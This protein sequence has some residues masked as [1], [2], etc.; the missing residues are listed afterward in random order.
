MHVGITSHHSAVQKKAPMSNSGTWTSC[1]AD[2][3]RLPRPALRARK[4]P[5][6]FIGI[7]SSGIVGSIEGARRLGDAD[8]VGGSEGMSMSM[9][10]EDLLRIAGSRANME[11][12]DA[13]SSSRIEDIGVSRMIVDGLSNDQERTRSSPRTWHPK[14]AVSTNKRCIST[15]LTHSTEYTS[16]LQDEVE[17]RSTGNFARSLRCLK[18]LGS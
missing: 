11:C 14:Q 8:R 3:I 12:R 13:L 10:I 15:K 7:G 16:Y 1:L 5:S 9:M 17:L 2:F 6:S 4:S 18:C